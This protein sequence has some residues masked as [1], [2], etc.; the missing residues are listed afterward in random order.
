MKNIFKEENVSRF[1][2]LV[3]KSDKIVL[4]CHMRPDGDAIGST[5]GLWHLLKAIGKTPSVVIPDRL[6]KSLMFLP[7]VKEVAVFTQH[8]PYCTRLVS[9]AD[10]IIMCDFNTATRQGI[11]LRLSRVPHAAR[12]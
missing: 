6:P 7:G 11:W 9:E 1:I 4:T 2:A 10:L 8:D 3:E 12:C 5:L